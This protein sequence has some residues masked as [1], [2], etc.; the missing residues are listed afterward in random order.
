MEGLMGKHEI[1]AVMKYD[2]QYYE[3]EIVAWIFSL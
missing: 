1:K 3:D 2:K